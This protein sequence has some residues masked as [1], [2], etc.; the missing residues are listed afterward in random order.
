MKNDFLNN[1]LK[2][3]GPEIQLMAEE[4]LF[5]RG[6][7]QVSYSFL[8]DGKFINVFIF[9]KSKIVDSSFESNFES[10]INYILSK[11]TMVVVL[12]SSENE[13]LSIY[14]EENIKQINSN[15]FQS[16]FGIIDNRLF[17]DFYEGQIEFTKVIKFIYSEGIK[18]EGPSPG[19][20][21][22][23]IELL[24]DSCWNCK[25]DIYSI[26][27][28]VFPNRKVRNWKNEDWYYYHGPLNLSE[29]PNE[30]ILKVQT[31]INEYRLKYKSNTC[32]VEQ[33]YSNTMKS[34]YW[35]STCPYCNKLMGNFHLSEKRMPLMHDY[36]GAVDSGK[37]RYLG[38]DCQIEQKTIN[39]LNSFHDGVSKIIGWE[40]GE[41]ILQHHLRKHS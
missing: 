22:I 20:N 5:K 4:K 35:S 14:L 41:N 40:I 11:D 27:G 31:L 8:K 32:L 1:D 37:L 3:L 38:L 12:Y 13:D 2:E 34:K 9:D 21:R 7:V 23:G 17:V 25:K 26:T 15:Y 28:I 33:N 30:L 6:N 39:K 36:Y 10:L 29:L 19:Y 18:F 24:Q 16:R